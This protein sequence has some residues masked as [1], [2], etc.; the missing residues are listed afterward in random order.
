[1][2]FFR[3]DS[4]RCLGQRKC[5]GREG[6]PTLTLP[7]QHSRAS[8]TQITLDSPSLA[9]RVLQKWP[10]LSSNTLPSLKKVEAERGQQRGDRP[11]PG[12]EPCKH[13]HPGQLWS[14]LYVSL[15]LSSQ[16][17]RQSGGERGKAWVSIPDIRVEVQ[18]AG[19]LLQP[20]QGGSAFP[21]EAQQA[22][23]PQHSF[24]QQLGLVQTP[25]GLLPV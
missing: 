20:G 19:L 12:Y 4:V 22:W 9:F 8:H 3:P 5:L 18:P 11:S 14:L 23:V 10:G 16:A 1:M 21:L 2:R 15:A 25:G 13:P 17:S 6:D 24:H 7:L